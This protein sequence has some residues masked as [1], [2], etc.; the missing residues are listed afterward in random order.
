MKVIPY[1]MKVL[2]TYIEDYNKQL[3]VLHKKIKKQRHKMK[4]LLNSNVE[5]CIK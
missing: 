1:T 2:H 3:K 5:I 4:V